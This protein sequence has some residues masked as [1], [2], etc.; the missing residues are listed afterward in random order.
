MT[1]E[2][3]VAASSNAGQDFRL[4]QYMYVLLY[5]ALIA[6]IVFGHISDAAMPI[7]HM[8]AAVAIF[9]TVTIYLIVSMSLRTIEASTK[10]VTS[11]EENLHVAQDGRKQPWGA[12]Q[13]YAAIATAAPLLLTLIAIYS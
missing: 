1:I 2:Y 11:E 13:I 8:I 6:I 5:P 7:K 12:F 10:D 3:R 9:G 4:S